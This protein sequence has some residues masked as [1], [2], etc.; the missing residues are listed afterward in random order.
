MVLSI[1][2]PG[3]GGFNIIICKDIESLLLSFKWL[4]MSLKLQFKNVHWSFRYLSY[5][6]THMQ[7][8]IQ[9]TILYHCT[10]IFKYAFSSSSSIIIIAPSYKLSGSAT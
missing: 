6:G 7:L 8:T 9:K 4:P 10:I 1:A 2:K 5:E 3:E